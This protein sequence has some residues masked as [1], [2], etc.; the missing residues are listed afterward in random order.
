MSKN[1]LST[2][3]IEMQNEEFAKGFEEGYKDFLL[4]DMIIGIMNE[5]KKTV[6][7]LSEETGLSPSIIQRMRSG[8]QK[9]ININNLIAIARACG[10]HIDMYN[11]KRRMNI[12]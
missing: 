2:F 11:E 10:Y 12:A 1:Q 9:G 8:K 4:S 3:E 7:G 5:N 6:R